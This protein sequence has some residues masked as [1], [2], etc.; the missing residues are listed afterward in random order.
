MWGVDDLRAGLGVILG[1]EVGVVG[2]F[3]GARMMW[4][5]RDDKNGGGDDEEAGLVS[6]TESCGDFGGDIGGEDDDV[7]G[8]VASREKGDGRI[9]GGDSGNSDV[10][11]VV[12]DKALP[13]S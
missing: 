11:G 12:E 10:R 13:K 2:V 5:R 6:E 7:H 4:C 3:L 8:Q 1:V 9:N